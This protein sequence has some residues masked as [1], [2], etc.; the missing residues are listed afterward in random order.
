MKRMESSVYAFRL[1]LERIQEL[2]SE[3]IR[4]IDVFKSGAG[5]MSL[6]LDDLTDADDFDDDDI[7]DD[8]FSIG[9][10]VKIDI[11]D[12][13]YESWKRVL[14]KDNEILVLLLEMIKDITP[15]HDSKLQ[16]LYQTYFEPM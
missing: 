7:N 16:E 14:E 10:K 15:E 12:M 13:D 5:K 2:I 11:A 9:R 8:V 6:N 1:T 4:D 3:T